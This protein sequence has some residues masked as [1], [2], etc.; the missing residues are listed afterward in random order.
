MFSIPCLEVK[1]LHVK[2]ILSYFLRFHCKILQKKSGVWSFAKKLE[3][4]RITVPASHVITNFSHFVIEMYAYPKL[5]KI[6]IFSNLK[7]SI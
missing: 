2:E 1:G 7:I 4:L 3:G 6:V 5:R